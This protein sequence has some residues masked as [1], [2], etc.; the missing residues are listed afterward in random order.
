MSV[1]LPLNILSLELISVAV[2]HLAKAFSL[3][4]SK[5]SSEFVTVSIVIGTT[6]H[7]IA[8]ELSLYLITISEGD[9]PFTKPFILHINPLENLSIFM[10]V[11]AWAMLQAVFVHAFKNYRVI[12]C[13]CAFSVAFS[14]FVQGFRNYSRLFRRVGAWSIF[15]VVYVLAAKDVSVLESGRPPPILLIFVILSSKVIIIIEE[16][17]IPRPKILL[18]RTLK[19]RPIRAIVRTLLIL[20]P[21]VEVSHVPVAILKCLDAIA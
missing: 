2:D 5:V 20:L 21:Q 1:F 18:P 7:F 17:P 3:A 11:L 15:N 19:T 9:L 14:I 4:V 10:E 13:Q 6:F 8:I 16:L 12:L